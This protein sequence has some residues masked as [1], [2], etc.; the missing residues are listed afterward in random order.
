MASLKEDIKC[1]YRSHTSTSALHAI[2]A[3]PPAC[4]RA[5]CTHVHVPH[6]EKG[7]RC[8]CCG[9]HIERLTH[10]PHCPAL[11]PLWNRYEQLLQSYEP[12]EKLTPR[13]LLLGVRKDGEVLTGAIGALRVIIWKFV[14]MT[15]TAIQL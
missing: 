10:L 1:Y 12:D 7:Q 3:L 5:L 2:P 8:R 13:L 11:K 9:L 14:I 15:F 6:P 4:Y